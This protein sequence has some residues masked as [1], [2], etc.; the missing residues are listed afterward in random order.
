MDLPAELCNAQAGVGRQPDFPV[1][2]P[3][4]FGNYMSTSTHGC[5]VATSTIQGLQ[6]IYFT[7]T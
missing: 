1:R 6:E 2:D 7:V 3:V 4:Q 5:T